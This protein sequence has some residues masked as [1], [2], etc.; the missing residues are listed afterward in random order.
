MYIAMCLQKDCSGYY[1]MPFKVEDQ[2]KTLDP[3]W[4]F[5]NWIEPDA[6][7]ERVFPL[8]DFRLVRSRTVTTNTDVQ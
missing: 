5:I 2:F 1:F 6:K 8:E 3:V 7:I 4:Y